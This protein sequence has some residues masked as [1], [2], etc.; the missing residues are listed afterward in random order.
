M[1]IFQENY[2]QHDSYHH[3]NYYS[4]HQEDG[5]PFAAGRQPYPRLVRRTWKLHWWWESPDHH[6][7]EN[8]NDDD[9]YEDDNVDDNDNDI[10]DDYDG[11]DYEEDDD[12][13][14]CQPGCESG[15]ADWTSEV[16][17]GDW[18]LKLEYS[19]K[20]SSS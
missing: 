9:S 14:L 6:E 16:W 12:D 17:E 10:D 5:W 11:D 4:D 8:D 19:I 1:I 15:Q 7:D 2:H 3:H 20:T 13:D 18:T